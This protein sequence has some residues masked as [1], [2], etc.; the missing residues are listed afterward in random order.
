MTN[1]NE[2]NSLA[3]ARR[4]R[5][6]RGVLALLDEEPLPCYSYDATL[7]QESTRA[8]KRKRH[9]KRPTLDTSFALQELLNDNDN[10][11]FTL[12]FLADSRNL[13]S[14]RF[15]PILVDFQQAS[16]SECRCICIPNHEHNQDLL[17][18]G[19]GF[20]C[21]PWTHPNRAAVLQ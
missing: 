14:I 3:T 8:M 17:C 16:H 2:P 10:V 9:S 1:E 4:R 21:L 5:P 13:N 15:R 7:V 6:R 11:E 19:T 20:Y 18:A 12:F